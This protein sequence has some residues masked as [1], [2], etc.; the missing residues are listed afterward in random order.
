MKRSSSSYAPGE[1]LPQQSPRSI[2]PQSGRP[3]SPNV[4]ISRDPAQSAEHMRDPSVP[5]NNLGVPSNGMQ[6]ALQKRRSFDDR[7][8][9]VLVNQ[10]DGSTEMNTSSPSASGVLLSP[11]GPTSRKAKRQSINP[12][13]VTSF[14][15]FPQDP[16]QANSGSPLSPST[17]HAQQQIFN[18]K[19]RHDKHYTSRTWSSDPHLLH[20]LGFPSNLLQRDRSKSSMRASITLDTVR[21]LGYY[22]A[23]YVFLYP[24]YASFKIL[25]Q[26]PASEAQL[27]S[28]KWLMYWSPLGCIDAVEC[29]AEWLMFWY[30]IATCSVSC[31]VLGTMSPLPPA[32]LPAA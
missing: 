19:L 25:L 24:D 13:L 32:R 29:V 3:A 18:D 10:P 16:P 27:Q 17:P 6:K 28:K 5:P 4:P 26:R 2:T 7:P 30:T 31:A 11:D 8:L 22:N 20:R 23:I 21:D 1:K 12:G 9:N 15:N 14:N